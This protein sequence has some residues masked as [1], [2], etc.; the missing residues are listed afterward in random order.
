MRKNKKSML[1]PKRLFWIIL[2]VIILILSS[3][4]AVKIAGDL[5]T[6]TI[7]CTVRSKQIQQLI[8]GNG[9]NMHTEIRY[10][11]FTNKELFIVE[12]SLMNGAY[13][14]S[15]IFMSLDT[16][17]QYTLKVCGWGKSMITEYRNIVKIQQ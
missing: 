4:I 5:K 11:V 3:S 9:E 12:N 16:G 17:K 1:S 13:N 8:K 15:E 2:F 7:T 10:L 6:E 14:N